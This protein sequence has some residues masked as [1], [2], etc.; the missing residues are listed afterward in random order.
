MNMRADGGILLSG[1]LAYFRKYL[2]YWSVYDLGSF[3]VVDS[4]FDFS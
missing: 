2:R 3:F 4:F 1:V